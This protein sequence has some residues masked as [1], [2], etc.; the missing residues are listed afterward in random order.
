MLGLTHGNVEGYVRAGVVQ[1]LAQDLCNNYR[2]FVRRR[3]GD[4]VNYDGLGPAEAITA[5]FLSD[6]NPVTI[7][8][9]GFKFTIAV[10]V[11]PTCAVPGQDHPRGRS[12]FAEVVARVRVGV[13]A[14]ALPQV[15]R[16]TDSQHQAKP[17]R[18]WHGLDQQ[19]LQANNRFLNDRERSLWEAFNRDHGKDKGGEK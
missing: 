16:E 13:V 15:P 7:E 5:L 6:A 14:E 12:G 10:A 8:V 4:S 11:G 18:D 9:H 19:Q 17:F 1:D 2:D 3:C